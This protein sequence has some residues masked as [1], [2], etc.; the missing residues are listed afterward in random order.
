MGF[1]PLRMMV[2]LSSRQFSN[3]NLAEIFTKV[4][5]ETNIDPDAINIEITESILME[6]AEQNCETLRDLK[7]LGVHISL[8]DF[9]TDYSSLS[10]LKHFPID[11]LKIDHSVIQDLTQNSDSVDIV[12]SILALK[13]DLQLEVIAEGVQ[14]STQL[15][16]LRSLGCTIAQGYLFEHP[17]PADTFAN[18]FQ[19]FV[20]NHSNFETSSDYNTFATM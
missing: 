8:V 9:S 11:T 19:P 6:D 13:K 3:H 5:K 14:T 4:M 20:F 2:N 12:S 1:P 17:M 16:I 15:S 18:Q 10:Y 7:K